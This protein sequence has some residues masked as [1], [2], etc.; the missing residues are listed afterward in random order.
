M[1]V[2]NEVWVKS[3]ADGSEVP[4]ISD[5]YSRWF[6]RWSPDGRQ[7]AYQRR[8]RRTNERQIMLWSSQSHEEKPLGSSRAV[9]DWSPDGK[10]LLTSHDGIWLVPISAAPHAE[11]AA[12]MI[13]SDR[14]YVLYQPYFSPD[15]RWIVFEAVADSLNLE[16]GIYVVPTSGGVWTR[17]PARRAETIR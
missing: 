16:S 13:T 4:V 14:G 8:N 5:D 12:R 2:R 3:L 9:W 17:Y 1:D 6:G 15:G 10:W 7:L 11:T